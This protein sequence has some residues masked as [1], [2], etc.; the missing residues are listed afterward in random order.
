[1]DP[2]RRFGS[3]KRRNSK[4]Q[5]DE[6]W[7]AGHSCLDEWKMNR[8]SND[9]ALLQGIQRLEISAKLARAL[10]AGSAMGLYVVG[11]A[12]VWYLCLAAPAG[13]LWR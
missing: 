10:K 4:P 5:N 13:A 11:I 12:S 1:M 2:A 6:T 7:P 8:A 9:N 3:M